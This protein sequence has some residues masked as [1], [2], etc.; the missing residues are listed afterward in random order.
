M[1]LNFHLDFYYEE[2][3]IQSMIC[4]H[5]NKIKSSEESKV[6]HYETKS[7]DLNEQKIEL[8]REPNLAKCKH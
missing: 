1:C 6:A 4:D 5:N 8:D 3:Q 7:E 2:T